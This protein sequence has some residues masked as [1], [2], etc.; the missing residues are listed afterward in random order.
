MSDHFF[1]RLNELA[2]EPVGQE[3]GVDPG[4][5]A[6]GVEANKVQASLDVVL[7]FVDS[8]RDDSTI[9]DA[10]LAGAI[11][12][13]F[14]EQGVA[15]DFRTELSGGPG[16]RAGRPFGGLRGDRLGA[17]D[18]G[19]VLGRRDLG[20]LLDRPDLDDLLER[21]GLS[22]LQGRREPGDPLDPP[23]DFPELVPLDEFMRIGCVRDVMS[24]LS[25]L[26]ALVANVARARPKQGAVINTIEPR[27]AIVGQEITITGSGFDEPQPKDTAVYIGTQPAPIVSWTDEVIKVTVPNGVTGDVCVS[28]LENVV[29]DSSA[30]GDAVVQAVE[31]GNTM[32]GCFGISKVGERLAQGTAALLEPKAECGPLN[33]IWVGAPAIDW[34]LINDSSA[35]A[36]VHAEDVIELTW[37][38]RFADQVRL[39]TNVISGSA[40]SS[41]LMPQSQVAA[42]GTRRM[43]PTRTRLVFEVDYILTAY[44]AAGVRQAT[45]RA[46]GVFGYGMAF[47]GA[48]TRSIFHAGALEY[49]PLAC[50]TNPRAVSSTGLG[51]LGALSAATTFRNN[52]ALLTTWTN[53]NAAPIAAPPQNGRAYNVMNSLIATDPTVRQAFENYEQGMYARLLVAV[54]ASINDAMLFYGDAPALADL[55]IS[56]TDD[57]TILENKVIEGLKDA[58]MWVTKEVIGPALED[59]GV[60]DS[61]MGKVTGPAK[62]VVE[63][64]IVGNV[65]QGGINGVATGLMYVNPAIAVIFVV[66]ADV[67]KGIVEG[68]ID[69]GKANALRAALAARGLCSRGPL[70][71]MIDDFITGVG[72]SNRTVGT[73][74]GVALGCSML[75]SG[76]PAYIDGFASARTTTG[77]TIGTLGWRDSLLAVSAVPGALAPVT[78][79]SVNLVDA[80]YTDIG[81]LE[82]LQ[83]RDVDEIIVVHATCNVL[84]R[85]PAPDNFSTVGFLSLSRRGE[86]VRSASLALTGVNPDYFW[87]DLIEQQAPGSR[88]RWKIR[89]VMP[90]I[91]LQHLYAFEHEPGLLSIWRDYGYMRAFDVMAPT[92]IHPG[93]DADSEDLRRTLR[94]NLALT[95][96]LIT[97][98]REAAWRLETLINKILPVELGPAQRRVQAQVALSNDGEDLKALR[99]LKALIASQVTRRLQMVQFAEKAYRSPVAKWPGDA[100][101]RPRFSTWFT[102]FEQHGYLFDNIQSIDPT[103][104]GR[105]NP[106]LETNG[107]ARNDAVPAATAPSVTAALFN[108]LP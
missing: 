79:G 71:T 22:G 92:L 61:D 26:G 65:V 76:E 68:A 63:E 44:N 3:A 70:V 9:T 2:E 103:G 33:H 34:F 1:E 28:V 78:A 90:T 81:P 4:W 86:R 58:G 23:I 57:E 74:T 64:A 88:R 24:G 29:L 39:Q 19:Y 100:V 75:E 56:I 55:G 54:D 89:H 17:R 62:A 46:T 97:G 7:A 32:T 83:R 35:G 49:L 99:Q 85:V 67:V 107:F 77:G 12:A 10:T 69:I 73:S 21:G 50:P 5:L 87:Q 14:D 96:D 16:A 25:K 59:G 101:P 41:I 48:G 108:P 91:A 38:T 82:I 20:A 8:V 51:A 45:V 43:G 18:F 53:I 6:D 30:K 80:A 105:V 102:E 72:L 106:W 11:R 60:S 94:N 27:S 36:Q 47:L 40:P 66:V 93:E 15:R 42:E 84:P 52:S 98:T 95:S 13:M 31:V 104:M 37:K